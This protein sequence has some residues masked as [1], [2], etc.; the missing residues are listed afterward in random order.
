[1]Q[2]NSYFF[3]ILLSDK[4]PHTYIIFYD[5]NAPRDT[6]DINAPHNIYDSN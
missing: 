5:I 1:M 6:R 4:A 3:Y 2:Y